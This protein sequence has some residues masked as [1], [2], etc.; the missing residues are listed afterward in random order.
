MPAASN[1]MAQTT[2]AENGEEFL[3]KRELRNVMS[4]GCLVV[5]VP[6][7][8]SLVMLL[9]GVVQASSPPHYHVAVL[10]ESPKQNERI[11]YYF[12]E[13]PTFNATVRFH[14][15][16]AATGALSLNVFFQGALVAEVPIENDTV[17][18]AQQRSNAAWFAPCVLNS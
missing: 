3:L 10:I 8:V 16:H 1:N 14:G 7:A 17:T 18:S 9:C 6:L 12:S 15:V 5:C 4:A 2:T 11:Y 13:N